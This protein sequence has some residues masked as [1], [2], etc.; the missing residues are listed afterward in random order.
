[1]NK[2]ELFEKI[3]HLLPE[4]IKDDDSENLLKFLESS[5]NNLPVC[6]QCGVLTGG[7]HF[8]RTKV[9]TS[10]GYNS[11]GKDG[12]HDKW[13][14]CRKCSQEFEAKYEPVCSICLKSIVEVMAQ[15]YFRNPHCT[16]YGDYEG[17]LEHYRTNDHCGLEFATVAGRTVCEVCY[18]DLI[19]GF[20][21]PIPKGSYHFFTGDFSKGEGQ[22]RKNRIEEAFAFT[23][24]EDA[25][26][27][28]H[29]AWAEWEELLE[30]RKSSDKHQ[31]IIKL[32]YRKEKPKFVERLKA[33]H[34][35]WEETLS[36]HTGDNRYLKVP[37]SWLEEKARQADVSLD[38]TKLKV[39]NGGKRLIFGELCLDA[40][41]VFVFSEEENE[42]KRR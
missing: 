34:P 25:V 6:N 3:A 42:P 4:E 1:M 23:L 2:N 24:M 18:E 15:L 19:S 31:R 39:E 17:A 20:K 21:I 14:L 30:I 26:S 28:F 32:S 13:N 29:S 16:F 11:T 9:A 5:L 35:D 8:D 27:Y 7:G 36:A 40:E 12:D 10:W 33:K 22:Q 41:D 37:V 38:L